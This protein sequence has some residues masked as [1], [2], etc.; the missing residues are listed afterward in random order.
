MLLVGSA[1]G[2]GD[3]AGL[4]LL[5]EARQV[6]L[7]GFDTAA[8]FLAQALPEQPADTHTDEPVGQE[9]AFD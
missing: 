1:G 9:V 6:L 5:D 4:E 3:R 8:I 2:D 7:L